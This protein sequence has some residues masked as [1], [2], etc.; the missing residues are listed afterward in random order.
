MGWKQQVATKAVSFEFLQL[1]KLEIN[2]FLF[3]VRC[4]A[5]AN[6]LKLVSLR[7]RRGLRLNIGAGDQRVVGWLSIDLTSKSPD[8]RWDIRW[9]IPFKTSTIE[10]I[11][12]EH[13][14]E[15]LSYPQ[16]SQPFLKE[17]QRVLCMGRGCR[18][19]V[20]DARKY[21]SAYAQMDRGFWGSLKDLGGASSPFSTEIEII[22]QAFRMGGEHCFAYDRRTLTH[23]LNQ[24]GFRAVLPRG[25]QP[26]RYLDQTHQWRQQ[27]SLY[28]YALKVPSSA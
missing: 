9:G 23:S 3:R 27:E 12:C 11:H 7:R 28:L 22:N 24:A 5:P 19:V 26:K 16:E 17:C 21:I 14:L 8:V 13:F 6:L 1:L 10:A 18:I 20:P 25:Y 2:Q 4:F 15:H